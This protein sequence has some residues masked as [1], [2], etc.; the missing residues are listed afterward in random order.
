[1]TGGSVDADGTLASYD[2]NSPRGRRM[3]LYEGL[4]VEVRR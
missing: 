3:D 4:P 1:M 2:A